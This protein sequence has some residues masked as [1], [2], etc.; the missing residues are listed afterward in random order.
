MAVVRREWKLLH[1][2]RRRLGRWLDLA[3][4]QMNR[5]ER[6]A[7]YEKLHSG[8]E[9]N[10]D[11]LMLLAL[12]TAIAALGLL[13]SSTA[14]VIGAMLVAPLMTPILGAGLALVQ[15]NLP[16]VQSAARAIILGYL[17]ALLI[18]F[19]LGSLFPIPEL[20]PELLAR[21]GPTLLDMGVG[22][23]SGLAAAYC[24]GRP[25]LIAALPGVAI[26]AALVPPIA[27]TGA[28]LALGAP[29]NARGSALLFATNVVAIIL[30]AAVSFYAGG[31]RGR[32]GASGRQHWV[33]WSFL[34]LLLG[35]M[36]LSAPLGS[37]LR[38]QLGVSES[39]V[40]ESL[41]TQ[42]KERLGI[43]TGMRLD[44]V[45]LERDAST[46]EVRLAAPRPPSP[47]LVGDLARLVKEE[48]GAEQAVRVTTQ[49]AVVV[50]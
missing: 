10:F 40:P 32:S 9:W 7:L 47:E 46:V 45:R 39:T 18:G 1:R 25:G 16:L 33:R 34:T 6:L 38:T 21:G 43:E 35:A 50:D 17:T 29:D 3:I 4:P 12:S 41:T 27:T 30:G 36:A 44:G 49:L 23:L 11:F 5:G 37:H 2:V 42:L 22:F 20:T 8:S 28:S 24:L 48:L 13:Q 15:G 19:L 31:V 14:V 26:A